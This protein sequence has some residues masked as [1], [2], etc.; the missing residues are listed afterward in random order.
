MVSGEFVVSAKALIRIFL[1]LLYV[2]VCLGSYRWLVPRLPLLSSRLVGAMLLL[3]VLVI[4]LALE[5]QPASSFEHWLRL[6]TAEYNLPASLASV[7][8][9]MIGA[10]ALLAARLAKARSVLQRRYL[11]GI[12]LLFLFFALDEFFKLHER[13]ANWTMIYSAIGTVVVVATIVVAARSPRRERIWQLCLLSG[14]A[15]SAAGAIGI[16]SLPKICGNLGYFRLDECLQLFYL[17]ESLEFLG[18]WLV[19]IA[20]LGQLSDAV[21]M[22]QPRVW[23]FLL[24]FPALWNLLLLL[25]SLIPILE[26]RF[27]AH[28]AS[29]EYQ[30]GL[31]LHGYIIDSSAEAS[32]IR[33]Y[34]SARQGDSTRLGYS[35]HL[36]DQQNGSSAAGSNEWENRQNGFW[37]L[38]PNYAPVYGQWI[39][40]KIPPQTPANRGLWIVL[41]VWRKQGDEFISQ[42]ILSSDHQLLD[43]T[44]V[45]LGELVLPAVSD[46]SVATPVAEFENGFTLE[47]VDLPERGRPGEVMTIPFTWRSEV[48]GDEDHVQFLHLGH[49][50]SGEWWINDQLPLG[51]R[52]PTR[53]WYSGMVDSEVWRV[54]VPADLAPGR[55]TVFTGLYSARDQQRVPVSDA[56]GMPWSDSR[57]ALGT[58]IIE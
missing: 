21:P 52:L 23:R 13:I 3:Q 9:S 56:E 41:T 57:V 5:W 27:L 33:L 54:P 32:R 7:Q 22:P 1:V 6:L 49:V 24:A 18:I 39:E 31:H 40:V 44:Q 47:S 42:R 48:A 17:E 26:V 45:V 43:E 19:L 2:P 28:P 12:G 25:I 30:S 35:I 55:Y 4:L 37:M 20:V 50:E 51:P 15:M 34:A 53:L 29:L 8:L 11:V 10:V 38:G 58:L 36:V 16:E 46:N 14:L